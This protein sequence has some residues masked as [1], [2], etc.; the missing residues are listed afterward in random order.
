MRFLGLYEIWTYHL[1]SPPRL[2]RLHIKFF[3]PTATENTLSPLLVFR[4]SGGIRRRQATSPPLDHH[5]CTTAQRCEESLS[6]SNHPLLF[7]ISTAW[8]M[9]F[10][11][12]VCGNPF[13]L[14]AWF[15]WWD[16]RGVF[17]FIF[18]R[19]S[20]HDPSCFFTLYSFWLN[21]LTMDGL[22]LGF[23]CHLA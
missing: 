14:L 2:Q 10:R 3:N 13:V 16:L 22:F 6:Q 17:Y 4:V 11:A 15:D 21:A 7:W 1:C 19:S 8:F 23:F 9:F 5:F 18:R 20:R 12:N